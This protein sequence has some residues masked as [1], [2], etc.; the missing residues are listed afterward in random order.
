MSDRFF[1]LI[2]GLGILYFATYAHAIDDDWRLKIDDRENDIVLHY[3]KTANGLTEFRGITHIKSNLSG[4]VALFRD[5]DAMSK[6]VDHAHKATVLKQVSDAE[7]YAH[8]VTR[9]PFPF[10]YRHSIVHSFISQDPLTGAVVINGR[11]AEES[12]L[13][14][15]SEEKQ[16]FMA[17][18]KKY[19]L[20]RNLKSHWAFRPQAGGMVEVEFQGYGNPGGSLSKFIPQ[21]LLRMFI[22]EAPY[23]TIKGMRKMVGKTKYQTRRFPFIRE[24]SVQKPN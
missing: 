5:V 16:A 23:N 13:V 8:I 9:M 3:R 10:T 1:L 17:K 22:W 12:Y 18:Q 20:I 11:D 19:V 15:L 24:F 4:F 14:R 6:W 21:G 2:L 7:V